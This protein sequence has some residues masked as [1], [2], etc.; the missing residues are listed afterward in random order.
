MNQEYQ[1]NYNNYNNNNYYA[2]GFNN[3][4]INPYQNNSNNQQS[5]EEQVELEQ[6]KKMLDG[7][8]IEEDSDLDLLDD[9]EDGEEYEL[10]ID[11]VNHQ[12][13]TIEENQNIQEYDIF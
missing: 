5:N 11:T 12:G 7:L 8:R 2:N 4:N 3:T 6:L 1:N 9:E 13:R 10:E